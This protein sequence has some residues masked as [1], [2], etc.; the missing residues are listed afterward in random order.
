MEVSLARKVLM[1]TGCGSYLMAMVLKEA[2]SALGLARS[3]PSRALWVA[4][5]EPAGR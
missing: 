3:R 4:V 1:V 5:R 2:H